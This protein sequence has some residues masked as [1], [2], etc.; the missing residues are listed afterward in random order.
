MDIKDELAA[1]LIDA[2]LR[3]TGLTIVSAMEALIDDDQQRYNEAWD[4][5]DKVN[6]KHAVTAMW[7]VIQTLVHCSANPKSLLTSV[8]LS[9]IDRPAPPK[10]PQ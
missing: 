8:E 7:C 4:Q 1:W 2:G 5:I 6:D 10:P 3:R 9:L